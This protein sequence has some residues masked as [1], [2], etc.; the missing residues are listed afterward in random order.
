MSFDTKILDLAGGPVNLMED[1]TIVTALGFA[2]PEVGIRIFAQNVST[3]SKVYYAERPGAPD[4]SD[5]GHCLLPGD[6]FLLR[7]RDG[8]PVGAWIWV[9]STGTVAVSQSLDE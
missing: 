7:L 4:R 8:L 2:V 9:A 6:G 1:T 3:R 5:K